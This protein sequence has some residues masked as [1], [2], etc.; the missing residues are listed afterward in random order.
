MHQE[1]ETTQ[2]TV[3]LVMEGD[4]LQVCSTP[5]VTAERL[6]EILETA[7]KAAKSIFNMAD[8]PEEE[9]KIYK[10]H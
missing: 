8:E 1:A 5:D 4:F 9:H 2:N 3:L 10:F 6:L 7:L